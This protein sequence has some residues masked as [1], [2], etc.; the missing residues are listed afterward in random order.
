MKITLYVCV[1]TKT[2]PENLAFLFPRTLKLFAREL[3]KFFKK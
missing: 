3:C 1:H 2:K